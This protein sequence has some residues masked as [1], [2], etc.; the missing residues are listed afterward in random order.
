MRLITRIQC[1]C[2][3]NDVEPIGDETKGTTNSLY[4]SVSAE[5]VADDEERKM[6]SSVSPRMLK[7][8]DG[9]LV[10]GLLFA[11]NPVVSRLTIEPNMTVRCRTSLNNSGSV[12]LLWDCCSLFYVSFVAVSLLDCWM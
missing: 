4:E 11:A 2:L 10:L 8:L 12:A 9:V 3:S 1:C 6:H 5:Q 7:Q